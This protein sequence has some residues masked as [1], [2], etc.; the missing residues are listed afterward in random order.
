MRILHV[1][2]A[3][4]LGGGER[5]LA[6]LA[7]GLAARGHELFAALRPGSPLRPELAALPAENFLELPLR[8]SL[9][10]P[11]AARL[12]RFARERDIQIIHAHMARDYTLA[13]FAARSTR[14]RTRLVITRHVLFPMSR[15]HAWTLAGAARVIAVSEPVARALRAQGIFPEERIRV[16]TNGIEF[17]EIERRARSFDRA[18]LRRTLAGDAEL[19]VG[20]VGELS[21]VKGHE[22]F[23]RAASIVSREFGGRVRFLVVGEDASPKRETRARLERLVNELNLQRGVLMLGRRRDLSE[24]LA[25]LDLFVSASR[26]EAFGLAI[27]EA[28][29]CGAP[30]LATATE[31]AREIIRDGETGRLTPV[32][33]ADTL[34]T[35]VCVLLA[36]A[37]ERAR[38]AEN[39]REA[40][41]TRFGLARMVEATEEIYREAL[42]EG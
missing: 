39:A 10:L 25:A 29:A 18:A 27:V 14:S 40:G 33:D 21:P 20:T 7:R 35:R 22:E 4:T 3:R 26:T 24:I 36:D 17:E 13:A 41:R 11:S 23:V 9:D 16:V 31:G 32:G 2:S 37:R 30:V 12:A 38:L 19:I 34:A 5:H 28:M 42:G 8:N 6:D 15:A 1:S